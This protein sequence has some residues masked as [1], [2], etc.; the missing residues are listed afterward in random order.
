[1]LKLALPD[2]DLEVAGLTCDSRAVRPGYVFA[3]LPGAKVDGREFITQAQDKGAVAVLAPSG[4]EA[5]IPVIQDDNVRLRFA[6]MA[7]NFYGRQPEHVAAITGTNGKTSTAA[8]LSQIWEKLGH[9]SATVGTLGVHGSGFE[10]PG[11]LTTPDPVD[12]H[13]TLARL[14]DGG[15]DHLA[16]EASS[17]GLEQFRLDGVK[18]KAAGFTNITRDHLDYHGTMEDY[19]AAKLRLFRDV[20]LDEGV[21]VVNADCK[22]MCKVV[23]AAELRGIKV[24]TFGRAGKDIRVLE[25]FPTGDGQT[26]TFMMGNQDFNVRLPLA[27]SFQMEN[28][29][30]AFGLAVALGA[31]AKDVAAGVE[32]LEGVPGRLQFVGSVNGASVYVDY[33]HT[34][35]ALENVL[36]ALR[37]HTQNDLH[38]VFGC[39][40]DRDTGKRPEMGKVATDLADSVIVTD[41]NPRSEDPATIRK[42]ILAAASGA[43]DIGDRHTAIVQA[44]W[45]LQKGDVLV[46]AGKGHEKGQIVGD[47]VLPFDDVKEAE[48]A[49]EEVQA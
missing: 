47:Q 25:R 13:H 11:T 1:M 6:Q 36:N 39:G 41:D 34:P 35:D 49:I 5:D 42:E 8:F 16:M 40:G 18:V 30:C 33:A 43:Q 17:H 22:D 28:V 19:F 9:K 38:V 37:P 26:I 31:N 24:L 15:V 23:E 20:L 21:A 10:E 14:A 3:A 2:E 44:V 46:L 48:Q 45:K 32:T 12:L 29:L 7:A 27:G 4:T